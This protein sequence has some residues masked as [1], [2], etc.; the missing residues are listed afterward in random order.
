MSVKEKKL[1]TYKKLRKIG[2]DSVI[3]EKINKKTYSIG[4]RPSGT[5]ERFVE[6]NN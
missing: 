4:F 2:L 5:Y 6:D 1:L 3:I